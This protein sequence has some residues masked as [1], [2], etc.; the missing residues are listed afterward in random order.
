MVSLRRT[1]VEL[2]MEA[3]LVRADLEF[4]NVLTPEEFRRLRYLI[5]FARLD[6]FEPG[7]A[8]PGCVRGRGG[9]RSVR[10]CPHFG[11]R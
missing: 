8:G 3:A 5:S 9:V 4:P 1:S 6:V 10:N 11:S 7:A 2:V